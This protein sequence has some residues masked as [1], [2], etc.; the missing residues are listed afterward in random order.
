MSDTSEDTVEVLKD[1]RRWIKLIGLKEIRED[2]QE[3]VTHDDDEKEEDNKIIFHL[4]DGERST[5]DIEKYVS[6]TYNTVSERQQEWAKAGLMEKS[7]E[8]QPYKKLVTL[9]EAGLEV[10]D[11]KRNSG[12]D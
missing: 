1:I 2:V 12:G 9:E 3:A 5:K 11:Y 4:T 10:P 6:V 8:N 7:A